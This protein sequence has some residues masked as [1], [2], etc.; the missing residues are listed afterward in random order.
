MLNLKPQV[1]QC[2]VPVLATLDRSTTGGLQFAVIK[3]VESLARSFLSRQIKYD[4]QAEYIQHVTTTI[5]LESKDSILTSL[6]S[7]ALETLS[8][9]STSG[10]KSQINLMEKSALKILVLLTCQKPMVIKEAQ[11]M[12]IKHFDMSL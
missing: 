8:T 9:A 4:R 12:K 3:A 5:S 6:I 10:D 7:F 2:L 11:V 1:E